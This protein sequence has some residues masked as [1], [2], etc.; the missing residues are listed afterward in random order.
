MEIIRIPA[1]K[2][3]RKQRVAAYCRVSTLRDEQ[4]DSLE[5][6]EQY[7]RNL[8]TSC[9][10]WEYVGVYADSRSGLRAE[11]REQFLQ[12][13]DDALNGKID[14]IICKS[15][16][17]FSRNV[18][19][20]R[21]YIDMLKVVGVT[22]EFEK[23]NIKTDDPTATFTLSIMSVV[24][25]NESVSISENVKMGYS[26]RYNRGEYNPGNNRVLGYDAVDGKLV[27]NVDAPIVREIFESYAAGKSIGQIRKELL[28][29]GVSPQR[30]SGVSTFAGMY[31]ILHNEV[32]KG[33]R[34][35]WKT[36]PHNLFTKKIDLSQKRDSI[37][38][39]DDHEAIIDPET[40][41]KVQARF[42]EREEI[43]KRIGHRVL[44]SNPLYGRFFCAKCGAPM[45]LRTFS[46]HKK[47]RYKVWV[48]RNRYSKKD[49]E[50]CD[51]PVI[52]NEELLAII[53]KK[54]KSKKFDE[55][56]FL[57]EIER[58]TVN[59]KNVTVQRKKKG[60]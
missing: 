51:S 48:C 33:D 34:C 55:K 27:P 59:G 23:E 9:P 2:S 13:I 45:M 15:I 35:L 39:V 42:K 56:K 6:Q 10:E 36:P 40:W 8:I 31:Y 46:S 21:R 18:V 22:V 11:K 41:D 14:R 29:K 5:I 32:Y 43:E 28:E 16:S 7:Y 54:M 4:E 49:E 53:A 1:K 3:L 58:V 25:E 37:Y 44:I 12:M 19:E 52:K 57:S 47:K 38:V 30:K 60:D 24:A 17:R 26:Y 20:C 50:R